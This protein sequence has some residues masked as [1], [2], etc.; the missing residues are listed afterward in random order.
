MGGAPE[1]LK[2]ARH[3]PGIAIGGVV[4]PDP[5][6]LDSPP[7]V[8]FMMR[9]DGDGDAGVTP[10]SQRHHRRDLVGRQGEPTRS[11][12]GSAVLCETTHRCE[13]RTSKNAEHPCHLKPLSDV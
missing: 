6:A 1:V 10:T 5:P 11:C 12:R 2:L 3:G 7:Q 4:R 13:D 9:V 8:G